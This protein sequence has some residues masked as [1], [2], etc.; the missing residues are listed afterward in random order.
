MKPGAVQTIEHQM[1]Q[2]KYLLELEEDALCCDPEYV[3]KD[4]LIRKQLGEVVTA[5][6]EVLDD[7]RYDIEDCSVES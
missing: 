1:L 5:I 6:T 2:A 7:V 3:A 4:A